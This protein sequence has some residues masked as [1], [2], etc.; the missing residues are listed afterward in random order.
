MVSAPDLYSG[1]LVFR[2]WFK[3]WR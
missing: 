2:S 1:G 3:D